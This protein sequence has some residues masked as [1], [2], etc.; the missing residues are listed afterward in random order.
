MEVLLDPRLCLG[1]DSRK[2]FFLQLQDGKCIS[3][4]KADRSESNLYISWLLILQDI[5]LNTVQIVLTNYVYKYN[6][7]VVTLI[8]FV[9]SLADQ[10]FPKVGLND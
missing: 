10:V 5:F 8:K 3:F 2:T 1:S 7:F 6:N 4:I 9:Q